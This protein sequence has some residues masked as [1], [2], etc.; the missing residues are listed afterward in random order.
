MPFFMLMMGRFPEGSCTYES[1]L[2]IDTLQR[3]RLALHQFYTAVLC[4]PTARA[5]RVDCSLAQSNKLLGG[6]FQGVVVVWE[7]LQQTEQQRK[8]LC[9]A[10]PKSDT[11]KTTAPACNNTSNLLVL[12]Y[13]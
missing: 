2:F 1:S 11:G 10:V 12:L 4:G 13:L 5:G 9:G 6:A 8:H 7:T 3:H